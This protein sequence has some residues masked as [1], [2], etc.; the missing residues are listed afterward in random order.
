MNSLERFR[1][2]LRHEEPDRVPLNIWNFR[3]DAQQPIIEKYV[4]DKMLALKPGG[5]FVFNTAH[6]IQPDTPLAV[7]E[8]AYK[9]ALEYGVYGHEGTA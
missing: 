9:T 5:G 4:R 7:I 1:T 3:P 2:T 8:S 6:T